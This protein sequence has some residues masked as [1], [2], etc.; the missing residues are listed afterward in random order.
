MILNKGQWQMKILNITHTDLDGLGC[1][2]LLK[3]KFD[4]VK[5]KPIGY[6][7]KENKNVF[8]YINSLD[9]YIDYDL[10]IISDLNITNREINYLE[11]LGKPF[12]YIDHH[13]HSNVMD[14]GNNIFIDNSISATHVMKKYL[15]KTFNM[16]LSKFNKFVE[17]V[18]DYD[19]A[20]NEKKE[21]EIM[22]M[23]FDRYGLFNA[24]D[25]FK[26]GFMKPSN[27][28][29]VYLK[30]QLKEKKEYINIMMN[31]IM[32]HDD[33]DVSIIFSKYRFVQDVMRAVFDKHNSKIVFI[34][35][36]DDFRISVRSQVDNLNLGN[37]FEKLGIG[38]GH[39]KACG[40]Y[41]KDVEKF[42]DKD[43]KLKVVV[44]NIESILKLIDKLIENKPE[45]IR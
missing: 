38:G 26:D 43:D 41:F 37:F 45:S 9:K 6:Y 21:S 11:N 36:P 16:D 13:E 35:N 42:E 34:V 15:E 14:N 2:I 44:N 1:Y 25:R 3:Q 10:I 5:I 33:Y 18:D 17:L 20:K 24:Y 29:M 23:L 4:N 40:V 12:L 22:N 7:S 27:E 28:E 19:L 30:K 31:S 39:S 8:E 32:I